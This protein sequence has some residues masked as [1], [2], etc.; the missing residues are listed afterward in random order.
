[1]FVP[2]PFAD[3]G[4]T[5]TV[6]EPSVL[7]SDKVMAFKDKNPSVLNMRITARTKKDTDGVTIGNFLDNLLTKAIAQNGQLTIDNVRE[8][9]GLTQINPTV[10][11][12]AFRKIV[13]S[14]ISKGYLT[15][16]KAVKKEEESVDVDVDVL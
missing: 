11:I 8:S 15:N 5:V 13:T 3:A 9:A 1:M 16:G 4:V 14:L 2:K 12:P 7:T 6:T 10:G